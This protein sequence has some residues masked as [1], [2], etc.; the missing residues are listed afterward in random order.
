MP[1]GRILRKGELE[2]EGYRQTGQVTREGGEVLRMFEP[3]RQQFELPEQLK[4][5]RNYEAFLNEKYGNPYEDER[6]LYKTINQKTR[7]SEAAL[8]EHV[9][10][11]NFRYEDRKYLDSKAQSHWKNSL[12]KYRKNVE[13]SLKQD[14]ESRKGMFETQIRSFDDYTKAFK[15][16][17]P[18]STM[19]EKPK[20]TMKHITD[21]FN[22]HAYDKEGV[23]VGLTSNQTMT[24]N[25]MISKS[26]SGLELFEE[27]IPAKKSWF[28]DIG[29][30]NI[31][32]TTRYGLRKP[33]LT[34]EQKQV[35]KT[36]TDKQGRKVIQYSDGT[37]EYAD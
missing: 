10:G 22:K 6:N 9:F 32:E 24:I 15:P 26:D 4:N 37:I 36:G 29:E 1:R 3:S 17:K 23:Y 16:E 11:N 7:G 20:Y 13:T 19:P 18:K 14:I 27:T 21:Y 34:P 2:P 5:R 28:G 8:F 33:D 35:V 25:N 12:L 30:P 31:P